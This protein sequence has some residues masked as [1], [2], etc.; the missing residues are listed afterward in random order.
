MVNSN[1]PF[2]IVD[3]QL[4]IYIIYKTAGP[5]AVSLLKPLISL[6]SVAFP[7]TDG[8]QSGL[9]R[10]GSSVRRGGIKLHERD[11]ETTGSCLMLG[12][13]FGIL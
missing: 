5:G 9:S 8:R 2:Y 7:T 11:A 13:V 4:Y 10:F 3:K 1:A 6:P 12:H